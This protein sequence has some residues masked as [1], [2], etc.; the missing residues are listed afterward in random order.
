MAEIQYLFFDLGNVILPFDHALA[1][2][3]IAD[4]IDASPSSVIEWI[5]DS[6][7]QQAF[8]CGEVNQQVFCERFS[9]MS[10]SNLDHDFLIHMISDIFSLN[11]ELIPL[12]AQLR[13]VNFSI[14]ILSNTC[15]AHWEFALARFP[16]LNELFSDFILSFKIGSMKPDALIYEKALAIAAVE[17]SKCLFVDDRLENVE[18]ARAL[19]WE[20]VQY[21]SVRKLASDLRR[22]GVKFNF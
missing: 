7:L 22:R 5:F 17:P 1:A 6:G 3:R 12:I 20:A 18:G 19:G 15:I 13:T 10:D 8:E 21:Q 14:G 4:A 9:K 16:I 11:R 2:A